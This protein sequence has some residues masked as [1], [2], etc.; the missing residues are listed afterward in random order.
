[1]RKIVVTQ[2]RINGT[3]VNQTIRNEDQ[4][5]DTLKAFFNIGATRITVH[6]PTGNTEYAVVP[7]PE[8]EDTGSEKLPKGIENVDITDT[9]HKIDLM[10][11]EVISQHKLVRIYQNG[12]CYAATYAEPFPTKE[13][14]LADFKANPKSFEPYNETTGEYCQEAK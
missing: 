5:D 4:I 14:A 11:K 10:G 12:R 13:S 8:N 1:M 3:P 6:Y 7:E 2:S 9:Y